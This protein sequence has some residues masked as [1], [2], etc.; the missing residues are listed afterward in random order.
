MERSQDLN[1]TRKSDGLIL[2]FPTSTRVPTS[3]LTMYLKNPVPVTVNESKL[4]AG[5]SMR[6]SIISRTVEG[7]PSVGEPKA[8]KS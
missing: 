4:G 2:P 3:D 5:M 1:T 7:V 8:A 6:A